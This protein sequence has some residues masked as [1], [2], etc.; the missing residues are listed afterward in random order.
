MYASSD[1]G[2]GRKVRAAI[3]EGHGV[4]VERE[5]EAV[6]PV[7]PGSSAGAISRTAAEVVADLPESV[8]RPLVPASHLDSSEDGDSTEL[9]SYTEYD[10]DTG[11]TYRCGRQPHGPKV[12]HT[13]G[14]KV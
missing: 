2:V 6:V 8:R 3:S 13:R 14:E 4:G 5:P 11:E 12:K 9:C 7:V 10:T 1:E